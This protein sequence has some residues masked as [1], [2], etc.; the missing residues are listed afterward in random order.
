M[1]EQAQPHSI[2]T[3]T[4]EEAP[5]EVSSERVKDI[6]SRIAKKYERFNAVS[7]FGAY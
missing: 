4:G 5:A 7:S 6:F 2:D 1:S 3:A